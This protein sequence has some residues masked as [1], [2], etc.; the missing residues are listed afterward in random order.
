MSDDLLWNRMYNEDENGHWWLSVA[1]LKYE[2]KQAV[3]VILCDNDD[4]MVFKN[5]RTTP[6]ELRDIAKMFCWAAIQIE[7]YPELNYDNMP[8]F[9][10]R[11]KQDLSNEK[12]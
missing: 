2:D 11:I 4:K 3:R 1:P 12:Q 7:Q 9:E 5:V 10:F 6:Q 8:E